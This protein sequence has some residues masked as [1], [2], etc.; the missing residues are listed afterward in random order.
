MPDD[1]LIIC[2]EGVAAA[3]NKNRNAFGVA[4]IDNIIQ[5]QRADNAGEILDACKQA[6]LSFTQDAYVQTECT[7]IV[8][9]RNADSKHANPLE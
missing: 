8:I 6:F 3:L 2:S 4:H 5:Q 9:K 1:V 7:L